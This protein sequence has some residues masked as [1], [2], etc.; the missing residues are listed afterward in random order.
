MKARIPADAGIE[1]V[2]LINLPE[3]AQ[4]DARFRGH[5]GE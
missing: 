5:D 4:L 3:I 1:A 2:K